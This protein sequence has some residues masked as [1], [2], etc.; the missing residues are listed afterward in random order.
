MKRTH[1]KAFNELKR[2]GAPVYEHPDDNGNFSI[3]AEVPEADAWADYYSQCHDWIFGVSPR[4]DEILIK[5]NL[6][7]EWVNPGR[8]SIYLA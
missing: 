5:H 1:I 3:D 6:H 2:L 7:G 8:L 4:L